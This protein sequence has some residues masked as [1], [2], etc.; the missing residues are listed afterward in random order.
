MHIVQNDKVS[1]FR[2]EAV[3]HIREKQGAINKAQKAG[4]QKN[5]A[6]NIYETISLF[7]TKRI[8]SY[9]T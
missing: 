3:P 1:N 2:D 9:H 8:L 6:K 7:C 4:Q 5:S